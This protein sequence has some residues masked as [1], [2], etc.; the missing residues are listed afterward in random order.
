MEE[1]DTCQALFFILKKI[2]GQL[3]EPGHLRGNWNM[4]FCTHKW[5][6]YDGRSLCRWL[7]VD[8][9][10]VYFVDY[11]WYGFRWFRLL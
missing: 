6:C 8:C 4:L 1:L 9:C 10:V 7:C 11:C 5:R 2:D 3:H